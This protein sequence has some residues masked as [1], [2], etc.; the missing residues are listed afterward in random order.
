MAQAFNR[1]IL[2]LLAVPFAA[3]GTISLLIYRAVRRN[4]ALVPQMEKC[5]KRS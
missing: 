2:L 3:V 1:G 5:Q 4:R